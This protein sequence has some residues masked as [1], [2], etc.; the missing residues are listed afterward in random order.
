MDRKSIPLRQNENELTDTGTI[1]TIK[2]L[3]R[4]T[5]PV[6]IRAD[7]TKK[8]SSTYPYDSDLPHDKTDVGTTDSKNRVTTSNTDQVT[9]NSS[10]FE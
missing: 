10:P 8:L 1:P 2:K 5:L 9:S 6:K 3:P 7:Q 4:K